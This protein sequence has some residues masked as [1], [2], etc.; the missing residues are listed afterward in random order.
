L[1]EAAFGICMAYFGFMERKENEQ[2][3]RMLSLVSK[4]LVE[5]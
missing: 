2:K 5:V 3:S 4:F 1:G